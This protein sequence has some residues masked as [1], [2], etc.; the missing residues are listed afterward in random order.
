[1]L[2][3]VS[4]AFVLLVGAGL[5][6]NSY[7]RLWSMERG[8]DTRGLVAM[9]VAPDPE[10][11]GTEEEQDRFAETLATRL[12]E[13]PG[14]RATA[15]NNLPLSGLGSGTRVYVERPGAE[16]EVVNDVQLTVVLNNYLDVMGIPVVAGRG[17]E[18]RYRSGTP[19]V[20]IV[21]ETTA[22]RFWPGE[23][24]IGRHLRI[25]DDSIASIE[26]VGVAADVRHEGLAAAVAPTLYLP[27]FQSRR[28]THEIV[29]RARGDI[30]PAVQSATEVVT[31]LS[32]ATPVGRVLVLDDAIADS[33]AIPRFRAVMVVAL[34]VLAAVIA[35][36][37]LYGVVAFTVAQRTK[38]I[39][40]R[41]ALGAGP[42]RV[43]LRVVAGGLGLAGAGVA[44]GLFMAWVASEVLAAFLFEIAPTDPVTYVGVTIGVLAVCT[45]AA[46]VPARRAATVDPVR[47]LKTE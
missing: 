45:A 36:L 44:L 43:V 14:M 23:P 6:G 15:V 39:G 37:G 25:F 21:S 2:V 35:L 7:L 38:E 30:T 32:L 41:M 16:A 20:A 24:A 10:S 29:L 17:F 31:S 47:V 33:V 3:E 5:L 13:V 8:F 34:A 26:I 19:P 9:R 1:M 4:L 42:R 18:S 27:A 40:I 46:A 28:D 11:Y 22:R 12:G